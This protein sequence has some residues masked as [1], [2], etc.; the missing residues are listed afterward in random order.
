MSQPTGLTYTTGFGSSCDGYQRYLYPGWWGSYGYQDGTPTWST[1]NI[2]RAGPAGTT[3]ANASH[4][5]CTPT[6]STCNGYVGT[7]T[8]S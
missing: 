6:F 3:H 8:W 2:N 4:N 1:S 5:L 7:D